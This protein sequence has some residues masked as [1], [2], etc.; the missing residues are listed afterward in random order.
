MPLK[1]GVSGPK[2]R[3]QLHVALN[4]EP[5]D[6]RRQ[7]LEKEERQELERWRGIIP[8]VVTF[9]GKSQS[10]CLLSLSLHKYFNIYLCLAISTYE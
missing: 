1:N 4:L 8:W 6:V 7:M 9:P 3:A 10:L 5:L 2:K